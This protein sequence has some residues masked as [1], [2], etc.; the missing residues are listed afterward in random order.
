MKQ[1]LSLLAIALTWGGVAGTWLVEGDA[2]VYAI[3]I[4][5]LGI[6]LS[7]GIGLWEHDF[8]ALISAV[9][10][11]GLAAFYLATYFG[12]VSFSGG[13][14]SFGDTCR[15][16]EYEHMASATQFDKK[17]SE[18]TQADIYWDAKV[19][20]GKLYWYEG[21]GDPPDVL[22]GCRVGFT[23]DAI[24]NPKATT[25]FAKPCSLLT[26]QDAVDAGG[27]TGETYYYWAWD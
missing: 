10:P 3:I 16:S 27:G 1:F 9:I 11:V 20:F 6:V 19:P 2:W 22:N 5:G 24:N 15:V 18:L 12:I 25:Y 14:L 8:R 4:F 26:D 17:C 23:A 21:R 7:I 13:N